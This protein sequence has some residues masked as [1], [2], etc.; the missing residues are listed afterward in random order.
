MHSADT[1][2]NIEKL[3]EC[4]ALCD[5][6]I[7][8]EKK[9]IVHVFDREHMDDELTI[10]DNNIFV[11]TLEYYGVV[12]ETPTEGPPPAWMSAVWGSAWDENYEQFRDAAEHEQ[13][14]K[15]FGE[16]LDTIR[17][18]AI[19]N[20]IEAADDMKDWEDTMKSLRYE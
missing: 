13:L 18:V 5:K 17:Y 4:L 19:S 15:K 3:T 20:N 9:D 7:E 14:L 11:D 6:I 1:N 10:V 16:A 12:C 8:Q 2:M